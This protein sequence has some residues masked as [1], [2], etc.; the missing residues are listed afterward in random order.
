MLLLQI[1]WVCMHWNLC[2]PQVNVLDTTSN[3][4]Q[5]TTPGTMKTLCSPTIRTE[6]VS[7]NENSAMK[8]KSRNLQ[9]QEIRIH[10][11]SSKR[12]K[13]SAAL[14][15]KF[16]VQMTHV[17]SA[18]QHIP[19]Q[20]FTLNVC[21]NHIHLIYKEK[22][23]IEL[24][25]PEKI[26]L[27]ATETV[28]YSKGIISVSSG[29]E[30]V[31]HFSSIEELTVYNGTG[32]YTLIP[33]NRDTFLITLNGQLFIYGGKALYSHSWQFNQLLNE[34]LAQM[35]AILPIELKVIDGGKHYLMINSFSTIVLTDAESR[36]V[37]DHQFLLYADKM[38]YLQELSKEEVEV[39]PEVEQLLLLNKLTEGINIH[40][41]GIVD[42]IP[43]TG[44]LY[45]QK[46]LSIQETQ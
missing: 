6:A 8:V 5:K 40:Q 20:K 10:Q 30:K 3:A 22:L 44:H 2:N 29:I 1:L 41:N 9:L 39:F 34:R 26:T 4:K 45:V 27:S 13:K 36:E 7:C 17:Y 16:R 46:Q 18:N 31:K 33:S 37:S 12:Y 43:G 38:L 24:T 32:M 15:E 25:N 28:L 35:P 42:K 23:I 11:A 14:R 21:N 19:A